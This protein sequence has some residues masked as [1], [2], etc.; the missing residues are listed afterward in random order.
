MP[1]ACATPGRQL[2]T[3]LP[4]LIVALVGAIGRLNVNTNGGT[5]ES[6]TT[7]VIT[8]VTPTPMIWFG[9]GAS[10]GPGFGGALTVTAT[11]FVTVQP[12]KWLTVPAARRAISP[13]LSAPRNSA[14][15]SSEPLNQR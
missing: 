15:S 8:S 10:V 12:P 11:P 4:A 3:P 14:R 1:S 2:K 5:A 6:V 13:A 9:I 7:L